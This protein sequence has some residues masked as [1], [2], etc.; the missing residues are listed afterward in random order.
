MT[1]A[2][3]EVN[4]L[5]KSATSDEKGAQ[6]RTRGVKNDAWKQEKEMDNAFAETGVDA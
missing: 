2:A 6:G 4:D 1:M 3:G 5:L